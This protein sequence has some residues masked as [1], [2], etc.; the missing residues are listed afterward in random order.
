MKAL[1]LKD[2]YMALRYC[3]M[4]AVIIVVFTICGIGMK[5]NLFFTIYP[6][7]LASLIPNTLLSYDERSKWELYASTMPF[8]RGQLVSVKYIMG[9]IFQGATFVLSS[10]ALVIR[11]MVHS[12]ISTVR[13]IAMLVS[14]FLIML[15]TTAVSLPI[16][17]K[18][19]VEKG[20]IYYY[21]IVILFG[22]GTFGLSALLGDKLETSSISIPPVIIPIILVVPVAL[23]AL[24]W[25]LSIVFYKKREF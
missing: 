20:R 17:F 21:V 2:F 14:L 8:T 23:Y 16:M 10:I 11:K 25:Y 3:R 13:I 1:I 7:L 12:D 4:F 24:S 6:C 18:F 15:M 19:G 5:N 22:G 9:L